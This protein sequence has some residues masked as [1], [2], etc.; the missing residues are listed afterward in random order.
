MFSH[1]TL[2][3]SDIGASARFYDAVLLPLGLV[4]R[5]MAP[6]GGPAAACWIKPG[7]CDG[8]MCTC[9]LIGVRR[10]LETGAWWRFEQLTHQPWTPSTV[11]ASTLVERTKAHRVPDRAT[12]TAITAPIFA[13]PTATRFTPLSR[14]CRGLIRRMQRWRIDMVTFVAHRTD[15]VQTVTRLAD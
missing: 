14:R 15:R 8:F 9:R 5:P 7:A 1:V 13:I 2:G 6:D 3:C 11:Q 4:R 10:V 12:E